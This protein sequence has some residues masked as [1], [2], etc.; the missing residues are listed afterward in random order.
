MHQKILIL[1][2]GA[3]TSVMLALAAYN[4]G[5][6]VIEKAVERT[7]YADFWELRQRATDGDAHRQDQQNQTAALANIHGFRWK[8][9]LNQP[10]AL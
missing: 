5:P 7:G 9:F 1:D 3:G 6:G 2:F 10:P 8:F 4:C